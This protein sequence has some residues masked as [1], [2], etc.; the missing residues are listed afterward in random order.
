MKNILLLTILCIVCQTTC[1]AQKKDRVR[2]NKEVVESQRVFDSIVSIETHQDI[3]LH[4][5]QGPENK[6]LIEADENLHK[7]I[8]TT[9]TN[10]NLDIDLSNK[11]TSKKKLELTLMLKELQKITLN[12]DSVVKISDFLTTENLTI[13]LN[14][15]SEIIALFDAK[16]F[17]L[18]AQDNSSGDLV[19]KSEHGTLNLEDHAKIKIEADVSNFE[20]FGSQKSTI[21]LKGKTKNIELSLENHAETKASN[22]TVKDA[23]IKAEDHTEVFVN[24]SDQLNIKAAGNSKIH[25]FGKPKIKIKQFED[26]AIL[27]KE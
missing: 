14:D 26:R 23:T 4:V 12:D 17:T 7:I 1:Y 11:I 22:L 18:N 3:V 25:I 6:L 2:G 20:I 9:L 21:T 16:N 10:G 8:L 13:N 15:N 27:Y 5:L 24:V 19:L